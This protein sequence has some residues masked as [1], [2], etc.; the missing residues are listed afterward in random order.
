M[1][2]LLLYYCLTIA[3]LLPCYCF[4]TALLLLYYCL[5]TATPAAKAENSAAAVEEPA[6][7]QRLSAAAEQKA[8]DAAGV[9]VVKQ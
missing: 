7:K 6:L 9:S 1:P 8:L 3:L 5:T 2:L 4:T